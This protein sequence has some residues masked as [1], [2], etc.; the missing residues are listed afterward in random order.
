MCDVQPFVFFI[1][2]VRIWPS[3]IIRSWSVD[4]QFSTFQL[5]GARSPSSSRVLEQIGILS[6]GWS[7]INDEITA[8]FAWTQRISIDIEEIDFS[9]HREQHHSAA[10]TDGTALLHFISSPT[11]IRNDTKILGNE[12]RISNKHRLR[13][14]TKEHRHIEIVVPI[15]RINLFKRTR[16]RWNG[17]DKKI[18]DEEGG[19]WTASRFSKKIGWICGRRGRVKKGVDPDP[20]EIEE[21]EEGNVCTRAPPEHPLSTHSARRIRISRSICTI[22]PVY[23]YIYTRPTSA[24]STRSASFHLDSTLASPIV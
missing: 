13:D 11:F 18:I 3:K 16:Y 21:N 5:R 8:R 19:S 15:F 12:G 2:S 14:Y 4:D 20:G 23:I 7:K 6:I 24:I 1:L 22:S 9:Y 17:W 10:W